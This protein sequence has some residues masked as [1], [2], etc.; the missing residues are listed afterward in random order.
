ML[1]LWL[2]CSNWSDPHCM[3]WYVHCKNKGKSDFFFGL[4]TYIKLCNA[5]EN[6][7][8]SSY[9]VSWTILKDNLNWDGIQKIVHTLRNHRSALSA[10]KTKIE[11][12]ICHTC[13]TNMLTYS[14][15][16]C[17]ITATAQ[18]KQ[19]IKQCKKGNLQRD[20]REV[21]LQCSE[22]KTKHK[23][24]MSVTHHIQK[25]FVLFCLHFHTTPVISVYCIFW[26]KTQENI[27]RFI[28][29]KWSNFSC[30]CCHHICWTL[31]CDMSSFKWIPWKLLIKLLWMEKETRMI[32]IWWYEHTGVST[33]CLVVS[34]SCNCDKQTHTKKQ[35]KKHIQC[36][37]G[38]NSKLIAQFY[39]TEEYNH[40]IFMHNFILC[41][42]FW[43]MLPLDSMIKWYFWNETNVKQGN[44]TF[45]N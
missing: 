12:K 6:S 8:I 43:W 35:A 41:S 2:N 5:S 16:T 14:R 27:L 45:Q 1:F 11:Y 20:T 9:L 17:W 22:K 25:I 37:F 4:H 23:L 7:I 15:L 29:K 40:T 30:K 42:L 38:K 44:T 13:A 28:I 26:Y 39:W 3:C 33:N 34:T 31:Q 19:K 21:F 18:K 36:F 10:W 24:L 32:I